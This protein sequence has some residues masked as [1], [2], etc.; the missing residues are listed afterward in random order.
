MATHKIIERDVAFI[1]CTLQYDTDT[2]MLVHESTSV[3]ESLSSYDAEFRCTC[4]ESFDSF[5]AAEEHVTDYA[6]QS[7]RPEQAED[8]V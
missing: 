3:G 6:T 2:G 7:K 8:E 1:E 5:E 4:G